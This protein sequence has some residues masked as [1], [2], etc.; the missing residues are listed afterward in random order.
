MIDLHIHI[1]PGMDDGSP[2]LRES[3]EMAQLAADCGTKVLVATP[4]C[5]MTHMYE[6]TYSADYR[7]RFLRLQQELEAR[8][9]SLRLLEGM[10]IF[11]AGNVA[12]KL[13]RGELICLNHTRYPLVEFDFE[14]EE[15]EITF[16]LGQLLDA[17]YTPVLAHPERYRC[18]S[19]NYNAVYQWYQMGVVIQINKGSVLG[20]FGRRVQRTVDAILRH[21]LAAVAASDAHSC[22]FR[23]PDLSHLRKV[24]DWNYGE[25]C[26][27]LL[28]KENPA[29]IL[30][31]QEVLWEDPIPFDSI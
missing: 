31:N 23:T 1:L 16:Q 21:R 3:V 15:S 10:E 17:G 30:E 9:P 22:E 14:E 19:R 12:A 5:N 26:S 27:W 8:E 24:L 28:L 6:N 4:H 29:R 7:N 11:A 20:G 18:V 25:G 2:D 13:R